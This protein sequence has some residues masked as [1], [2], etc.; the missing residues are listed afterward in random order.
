[1]DN[2]EKTHRPGNIAVSLRGRRQTESGGKKYRQG[3][4]PEQ[5]DKVF[6]R[7]YR[8]DASVH[9]KTGVAD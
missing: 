4:P 8:M 6:E 9:K 1:M 2:A 3:I 7:F 5:I